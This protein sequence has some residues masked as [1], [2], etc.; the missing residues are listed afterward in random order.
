MTLTLGFT[1]PN[2]HI[3]PKCGQNVASWVFPSHCPVPYEQSLVALPIGIGS[4]TNRLSFLSAALRFSCNLDPIRIK[5]FLNRPE[6]SH[7][8]TKP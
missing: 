2:G 1:P 4:A 6:K 7:L 8:L 5:F 3:S